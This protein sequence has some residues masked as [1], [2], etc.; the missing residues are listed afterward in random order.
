MA[1]GGGLSKLGEQQDAGFARIA[2]Q[3]PGSKE[4]APP[5]DCSP[6]FLH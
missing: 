2:F 6:E 4:L 3:V 5:R 1:E